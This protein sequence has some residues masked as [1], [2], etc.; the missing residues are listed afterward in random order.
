MRGVSG[1][2]GYLPWRQVVELCVVSRCV[3][4]LGRELDSC[5]LPEIRREHDREETGTTVCVDEMGGYGS[6]CEC[7]STF[8]GRENGIANVLDERHQDGIV[9]L[10]ERI[11]VV[12]EEPVA[13]PFTDFGAVVGHA[14]VLFFFFRRCWRR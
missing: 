12:L 7:Q 3:D 13:D 9:V 1:S 2:E 14:D 4:G 11:R 6:R 10:E 5:D 8:G